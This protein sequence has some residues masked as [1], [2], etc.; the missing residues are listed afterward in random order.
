VTTDSRQH[1]CPDA[2]TLGAFV[3]GRL[4]ERRRGEVLAHL[5]ECDD[6]RIAFELGMEAVR[7][8]QT[9]TQTEPQQPV[10][11][12]GR[13]RG[14]G[15]W[16]AVAAAIVAAFLAVPAMRELVVGRFRP[17]PMAR[18]VAAMP[19][20]RRTVEPRLSGGFGWATYSSPVRADRTAPDPS[21][22]KLH[23]A[24]G[25]VLDREVR[26]GSA[27]T[28][29]AAGVALV[30][31]D[32][33]EE[34]IARLRELAEAAPK[35]ARIRND[36]AAAY[37]SSAL[38]LGRAALYPQ[39]LAAADRALQL[40]PRMA[41]ALFNRALILERMGLRAEARRSWEQY[42]AVDP[43]SA[44]AA[45]ARTHLARLPAQTGAFLFR[46]AIPELERRTAANDA[47][48]I[49]A[50]I[51]RYRQQARTWG[52][53]EFLGDWAKAER[54]GDAA[55]AAAKLRVARMIGAALLDLS[56]E[57]LLA[58]AV[59]AI[60]SA[61]AAQR[62]ALVEAHTLYRDGRIAYSRRTPAEAEPLLRRAGER[63]DSGGSPMAS[64]ARYFAAN[65][66]FDQNRVDEARAQ[67]ET[68]R[69]AVPAQY[70]ALHAQIGWELGLC[71]IVSGEWNSALTTLGE[72]ATRF[73]RLGE[74]SN[75]AFLD[76]L[77]A[78]VLASLGRPNESWAAWIAAFA[79]LGDQGI[80]DQLLVAVDAAARM[81]ID[82]RRYEAALAMLR[83]EAT[84]A[85]AGG[86]DAMLA[87]S[88][89]RQVLV[90]EKMGGYADADAHLAEA[91]RVEPRIADPNVRERV[92]A[93]IRFAAGVVALRSD[94]LRARQQLD[95][96][97]RSYQSDNRP[98]FLPEAYLQRARAEVN[99]GDRGAARADL[100]RGLAALERQQSASGP[101]GGSGIVEVGRQLYEAAIRHAL[102]DGDAP[103]AFAYAERRHGGD[104]ATVDEV[105]QR[106]AGSGT[107]VLELVVLDDEV[108]AFTVT[109]SSFDAVRTPVK[110]SHLEGLIVQRGDRN[111]LASLYRSLIA[112][113]EQSI[114]PAR[115]L[116]VV[117]DRLLEGVPFAALL[118]ASGRYLVERFPVT[119]AESAGSLRRSAA[120]APAAVVVAEL[121]PREGVVALAGVREEADGV[122]AL[123]GR[124]TRL[125]A[126][127]FQSFIDAARGGAVVHLAGHAERETAGAIDPSLTFAA[128]ERVSW[129]TVA[130]QSLRGTG[131]VVLAACETLRS[132]E[133]EPTGHSIAAGFLAAGAG[134]VIGTLAPIEDDAARELFLDIHRHLASGDAAPVA[135]RKAQLRSLAAGGRTPGAWADVASITT[136]IEQ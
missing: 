5:D 80:G 116:T 79:K 16:L 81:E 92:G 12:I 44:W 54:Q 20:E 38:R 47:R 19:A 93:D 27:D 98:I 110:R 107:A 14:R 119:L 130:R 8:T 58:D 55:T 101:M 66:V 100:D 35:D 105:R 53:A 63:F 45:E 85:R 36:L 4:D 77:K 122:S 72:A 7:D 24:A 46:Q 40:D 127:S 71:H 102:D 56:G 68:L 125:Q 31:I 75:A 13:R 86:D 1:H 115:A 59:Q 111:A 39:A 29:H 108:I 109:A 30:L 106:L 84:H 90:S 18:L 42:L 112:P 32:R 96:A 23:G 94:A 65:T 3:E 48:A 60:D 78:E 37:Y 11:P 2:E 70:S 17:T 97:I 25:E 126:A 91:L 51:D 43:S 9:M 131:V 28:K 57:R 62:S 52:E 128:D 41:E 135:V 133:A 124:A 83:V 26:D 118:D 50:S 67:L 129:R 49:R 121:P 89:T 136:R 64:V 87:M 132:S 6:C 114:G 76:S 117:A 104:P 10:T 21:Q 69:A 34:G 120:A 74:T 95:A 123:Y 103:R 22:L 88:L 113:S 61:D 99:A 15:I 73:D 82:A 33:P 134:E